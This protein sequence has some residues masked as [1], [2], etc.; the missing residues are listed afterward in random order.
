VKFVTYQLA[1]EHALQLYEPPSSG[2]EPMLRG[3][4]PGC[5]EQL[6][7][8][9]GRYAALRELDAAGLPVTSSPYARGYGHYSCLEAVFNDVIDALQVPDVVPDQLTWTRGTQRQMLDFVQ[10]NEFHAVEVRFDHS[11]PRDQRYEFRL[12]ENV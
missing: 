12:Q 2:Q 10:Y 7:G 8:Y 4:C 11:A 1:D 5:G 6:Y 9:L 3:R